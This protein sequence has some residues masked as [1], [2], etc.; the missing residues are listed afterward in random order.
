VVVVAA[1][2]RDRR[3][4]CWRHGYPGSMGDRLSGLVE[5][6]PRVVATWEAAVK[7][8]DSAVCHRDAALSRAERRLQAALGGMTLCRFQALI[9]GEASIRNHQ[10]GRDMFLARKRAAAAEA[11]VRSLEEVKAAELRQVGFA[12]Q[13]LAEATAHL[14]AYGPAASALTTLPMAELHLQSEAGSGVPE[15]RTP[16]PVGVP[17]PPAVQHTGGCG[18]RP[19][20]IFLRGAVVLSRRGFGRRLGVM[21][22]P[23]APWLR[24]IHVA[25]GRLPMRSPSLR[26]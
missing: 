23:P 14:L 1:D 19:V 20:V 15:Y 12:D 22:R 16:Q 21:H 13:A 2:L 7:R 3:R 25:R 24:R 8:R 11:A 5:A 18:W 10:A 9:S 26:D 4:G 17:R 6:L